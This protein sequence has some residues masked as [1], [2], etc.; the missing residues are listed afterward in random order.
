M[1]RFQI[2]PKSFSQVFPPESK[3]HHRFQIPQLIAC[4]ISLAGKIIGIHIPASGHDTEGIGKLD[5]SALAGFR[6]LQDIKT[7]G[8]ITYLQQ[9]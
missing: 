5:F 2:F 7:S 9:V 8:V 6:L 4:I 1:K 3:L